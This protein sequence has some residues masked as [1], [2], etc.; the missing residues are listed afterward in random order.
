[1]TICTEFESTDT[2]K[3]MQVRDTHEQ[4]HI[5]KWKEEKEYYRDDTISNIQLA[6][7]RSSNLK[8]FSCLQSKII[9]GDKFFH[10]SFGH[11]SVQYSDSKDRPLEKNLRSSTK[12]LHMP[13]GC[14]IKNAQYEPQIRG[15]QYE[16]EMFS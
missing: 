14:N 12:L 13:Q 6:Q 4:L 1:M 2:V 16:K 15:E 10:L 11:L 7:L 3:N 5:S 9:T 8:P